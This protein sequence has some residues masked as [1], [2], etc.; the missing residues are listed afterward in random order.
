MDS[1]NESRNEW[2]QNEK[3]NK[4]NGSGERAKCPKTAIY[5][6]GISNA[7]TNR[8]L[9]SQ[10]KIV[11]AVSEVCVSLRAFYTLYDTVNGS[12]RK[13]ESDRFA[14]S[15]IVLSTIFCVRLCVRLYAFVHYYYYFLLFS[16]LFYS[17]YPSTVNGCS[18]SL[19][20][21]F[22]LFTY[23]HL[24][25][26]LNST[27]VHKNG[28]K[29]CTPY[30]HTH[31]LG[32]KIEFFSLSLYSMPSNSFDYFFCCFRFCFCVYF[33]RIV[34]RACVLVSLCVNECAH[35]YVTLTMTGDGTVSILV[36]CVMWVQSIF[37]ASPS[38]TPAINFVFDF[39][40]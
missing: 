7:M 21:I 8:L 1:A 39:Y 11:W 25:I 6:I 23:V 22:I 40:F 10:S 4:K 38:P 17:I 32:T 2:R 12:F 27:F 18:N 31:K 30:A 5:P 26:Q 13:R 24:S 37:R 14:E 33:S 15:T 3:Q 9:L 16:I 29:K 19:S 36:F 35:R 20:S 28:R 34:V